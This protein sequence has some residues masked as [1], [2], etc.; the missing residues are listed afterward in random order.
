M[1]TKCINEKKCAIAIELVIKLFDKGVFCKS[2]MELLKD[3]YE[4]NHDS[5]VRISREIG[6]VIARYNELQSEDKENQVL[7]TNKSVQQKGE[8]KFPVPPSLGFIY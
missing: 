7:A 5:A 4:N 1:K 8:C 3:F 6:K 2:S